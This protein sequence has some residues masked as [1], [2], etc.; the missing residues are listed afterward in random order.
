MEIWITWQFL[1]STNTLAT[2]TNIIPAKRWLPFLQYLLA[3]ITKH[4][5]IYGNCKCNLAYFDAS[6]SPYLPLSLLIFLQIALR[7]KIIDIKT[8]FHGGWV[9]PNIYFLGFGGVV[10]VNGIRIAG[11]TG[12]FNNNHY[13]WGF[14]EKSPYNS[15]D[16]RSIYHVRKYNVYRL[17]QV[18]SFF[19]FT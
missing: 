5:T 12:I 2:S 14:H 15:S 4:Q 11:L 3:A 17:A 1:T 13:D 18:I 8:R 19:S 10:N 6:H 16:V 7:I 9:C